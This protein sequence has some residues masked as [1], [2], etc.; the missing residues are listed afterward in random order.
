MNIQKYL[1]HGKVKSITI[2]EDGD[3]TT[4]DVAITANGVDC[5]AIFLKE[6]G[7]FTLNNI[8]FNF[9]TADLDVLRNIF[10]DLSHVDLTAL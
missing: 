6:K 1:K 9:E 7:K 8:A 2:N 10:N 4:Y 3:V 5:N